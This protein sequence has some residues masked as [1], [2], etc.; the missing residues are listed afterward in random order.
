MELKRTFGGG[1]TIELTPQ[2]LERL[3]VYGEYREQA[4]EEPFMS[5]AVTLDPGLTTGLAEY[6]DRQLGIF[7]PP[8]TCLPADLAIHSVGRSN[9]DDVKYRFGPFSRVLLIGQVELARPNVS[10]SVQ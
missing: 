3:K 4:K 6:H 7:L 8:D 9:E 5:V 2:E 1:L 10:S